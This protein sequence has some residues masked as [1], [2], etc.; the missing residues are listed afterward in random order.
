MKSRLC[1]LDSAGEV[2]DA[3]TALWSY[4][5]DRGERAVASAA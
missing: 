4:E 2:E 5:G 1:R 3:V